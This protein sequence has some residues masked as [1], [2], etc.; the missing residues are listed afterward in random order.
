MTM[1]WKLVLTGIF[2]I[3]LL[4]LTACGGCKTDSD[5]KP[6]N[7]CFLAKCEANKCTESPKT[8]CC[9][10]GVKEK[11][12]GDQP[13]SKCTCPQDYGMCEGQLGANLVYS[14]LGNECYA[15]IDPKKVTVVALSD[16]VKAKTA[17]LR[18]T[19]TFNQ[20]YNLD[21]DIFHVGIELKSLPAGVEYLKVTRLELS[22]V[23]KQKQTTVLAEKDLKKTLWSAG[24][25]FDEELILNFATN[26]KEDEL[27]SPKLVIGFEYLLKAATGETLEKGTAEIK[28]KFSKFVYANPDPPR[29]CPDSCDDK[30]AATTDSCS[31]KT[32]YFC[33]HTP[34]A[35][36]CGN[37][38][39]ESGESKCT[40]ELDCG[41][42]EGEVGSYMELVCRND[43]CQSILRRDLVL[44]PVFRLD[45]RGI[46]FGRVTF[47][48]KY[49]TPFSMKGSVFQ[50]ELELRELKEDCSNIRI[51]N[52]RLLERDQVLAEEEELD[53]GLSEVGDTTT[54]SLYPTFYMA[55]SEQRT[56]S[57]QFKLWYS[58]DQAVKS[59]VNKDGTPIYR[60]AN[61][62]KLYS[63]DVGKIDFVNPDLR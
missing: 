9:G 60:T 21:K 6:T 28:L 14:C 47:K 43:K 55:G 3:S 2:L 16:D 29:K 51:T 62:K 33:L 37:E 18:V 26:L 27:T 30:D 41:R 36:K 10:N 13:G 58:Y 20:T 42:C 25:S 61:Y 7:D 22:A 56:R 44:E 19:S 4:F 35:G 59:G 34:I 24:T 31:E 49:D 32:A 11:I 15:L 52:A 39:C 57:P 12:E 5:C 45:D 8:N 40:C 1:S 23:N 54:I 46:E 53:R 63:F 38:A 50:V 48:Y 17:D